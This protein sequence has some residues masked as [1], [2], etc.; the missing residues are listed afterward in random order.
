M[1]KNVY[2]FGSGQADGTAEMRNLLGGKGGQLSRNDEFGHSCT[3]RFHH[4]N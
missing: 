1:S 4:Y 3:S 2:F